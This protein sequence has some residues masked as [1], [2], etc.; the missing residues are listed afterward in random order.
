MTPE[1][2]PHQ[3]NSPGSPEFLAVGKLRRPHGLKG[4]ILMDILTDFPERLVEGVQLFAGDSRHPLLIKSNRPN[5]KSMLISFEGYDTPESVGVLRNQIVYVL[6]AD[7]PALPEGEYY[8]HQLLG[9]H[10]VDEDGQLLGEVT[11]I[12]DTGG[13]N[14]VYQV[15]T[16]NGKELLL[17][18]TEEVVLKIDLNAGEMRVHLLPGLFPDD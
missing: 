4:E 14:D 11:G 15:S 3:S 2:Q 10:V 8:H 18:D 16:L 13:A 12:L 5:N 1:H 6:A 7:R 17:P 9:L